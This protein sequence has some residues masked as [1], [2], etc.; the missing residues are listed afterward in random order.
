M[1]K[2]FNIYTKLKYENSEIIYLFKSGIFYIALDKDAEFLSKKYNYK[3]TNLTPD[4]LKCGFPC[5]SFD[6]HYLN[7]LNDNINFKIIENN[8]IFEINEYIQNDKLLSLV[9]KIKDINVNE[10]SVSEAYNFIEELKEISNK[11]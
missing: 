8:T 6:K 11:L 2:L 9:N 1:S 7:F 5:T 10:L 3:L 4:V